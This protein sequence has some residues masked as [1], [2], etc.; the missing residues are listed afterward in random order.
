M[1]DLQNRAQDLRVVV[2][3]EPSVSTITPKSGENA[4]KQVDVLNLNVYKPKAEKD[5]DG[6]WKKLDPDFFKLQLFSEHAKA[7]APLLKDGLALRV[8]GLIKEDSF[9]GRDGQQKIAKSILV[10]N[11]AIDLLQRGINAIDFQKPM[12]LENTKVKETQVQNFNA[13]SMLNDVAK[14]SEKMLDNFAKKVQDNNLT[15]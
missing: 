15:F 1:S 5:Q 8:S 9:Q 2:Y 6:K 3:G 12:K 10:N 11:I 14:R 7:I 4:G 13:Q